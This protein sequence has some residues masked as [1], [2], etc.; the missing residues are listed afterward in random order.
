MLKVINEATKW[1]RRKATK[2]SS[3]ENMGKCSSL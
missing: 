3:R 1:K 2:Q